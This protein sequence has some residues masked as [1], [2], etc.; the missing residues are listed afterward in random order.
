MYGRSRISENRAW[1]TK[2]SRHKK[3]F[4][5]TSGEDR[6]GPKDEMCQI[7]KVQGRGRRLFLYVANGHSQQPHEGKSPLRKGLGGHC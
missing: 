6:S 4:R 7:P 2:G 1:I 5:I 3:T